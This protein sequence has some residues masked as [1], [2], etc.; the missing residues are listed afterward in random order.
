MPV[1][2]VEQELF[3]FEDRFWVSWSGVG[4]FGVVGWLLGR[5]DTGC[6]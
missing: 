1:L 6:A 2:M 4:I 5:H 3:K